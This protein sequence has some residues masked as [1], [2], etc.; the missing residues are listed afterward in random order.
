M[1]NSNSNPVRNLDKR[2][3]RRIYRKNFKRSISEYVLSGSLTEQVKGQ[4]S[5]EGEEEEETKEKK[6]SEGI[7]VYVR[8]RPIFDRERKS[9]EF[10]V[11]TCYDSSYLCV[12]DARMEAD[13][14]TQVLHNHIFKF[15][16]VFDQESD[17]D[18]VYANAAEPLVDFAIK[19][20]FGTCLMYVLLTQHTPSQT[21]LFIIHTFHILQVRPDRIR[22]DIYDDIHLRK[23]SQRCV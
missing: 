7:S 16:R 4:L 3:V 11:L 2:S 14:M 9:K 19:G 15:D 1:G 8:K 18:E 10:D 22:K 12:H 20:G 13:M 21:H 5:E 23:S 6:K 17:N